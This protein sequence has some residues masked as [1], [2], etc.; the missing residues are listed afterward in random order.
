MPKLGRPA[1]P[2]E[3]RRSTNLTFRVRPDLHAK[4]RNAA[5]DHE[6]S[7][8]AEIEQRLDQSF[9][10]D[11]MANLVR[12]VLAEEIE[13]VLGERKPPPETEPTAPLVYTVERA[14]E[15]LGI[16]RN[17]AYE[18]ARRGDFPI[19]KIGRLLRVPRFAFDKFLKGIA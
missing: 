13:R 19:I 15:M 17:A 16:G 6:Q 2:A 5:T 4:L 12:E 14:G 10:S 18:A 1:I 7:M 9:H 11:R 3:L 8:A